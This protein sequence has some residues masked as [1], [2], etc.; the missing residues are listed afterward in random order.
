MSAPPS[1]TQ[2]AQTALIVWSDKIDKSGYS[3]QLLL[4]TIGKAQSQVRRLRGNRVYRCGIRT[5]IY[6]TG[7]SQL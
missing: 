5:P 1:H 4:V 7:R 2:N 6:Y 3:S